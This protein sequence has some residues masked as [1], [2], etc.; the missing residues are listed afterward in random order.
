[1]VTLP[2]SPDQI[3]CGFAN[4]LVHGFDHRAPIGREPGDVVGHRRVL[5]G[6]HPADSDTAVPQGSPTYDRSH[7]LRDNHRR[8][9][10]IAEVIEE[11]RALR[12]AEF[13]FVA[14]SQILAIDRV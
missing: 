5:V 11:V 2:H 7:A 12:D 9:R 4:H 13:D 3:G 14:T 6:V 1:M 8:V 10:S